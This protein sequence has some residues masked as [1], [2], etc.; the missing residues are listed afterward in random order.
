M[1]DKAEELINEYRDLIPNILIFGADDIRTMLENNR[2][3]AQT[4]N[5]F[6]LPGDVLSQMQ[7]RMHS[8]KME[9][10]RDS[11]RL[12]VIDPCNTYV[13]GRQRRDDLEEL[14]RM[15]SETGQAIWLYGEGGIGKTQIMLRFAQKHQEYKYVF[16]KY[17]SSIEQTVSQNLFFL[18]GLENRG[19]ELEDIV[20]FE[21]NMEVFGSYGQDM[22]L[23]IDGYD[24]DN[25]EE[26]FREATE[27][28]L[29]ADNIHIV[30]SDQSCI[31]RLLSQKI[32][33]IISTRTNPGSSDSY[34]I[35][36]IQRMDEDELL[37]VMLNGFPAIQLSLDEEKELMLREMIKEA[38]HNTVIIAIMAAAMQACGR[39]PETAL[40]VLHHS[41]QS[42]RIESFP[43]KKYYIG[44]T[45]NFA[46]MAQHM[47][48][49][50]RFLGLNWLQKE[51]LRVVAMLPP[52][53]VDYELYK[54]ITESGAVHY[55]DLREDM[56]KRFGKY[57]LLTMVKDDDGQIKRIRVH[58]MT[59]RYALWVLQQT[60]P[61]PLSE[62]LS[63][64]WTR[65][66]LNYFN[67]EKLARLTPS[68][69]AY[70]NIEKVARLC[71]VTESRLER[72]ES[73]FQTRYQ[74]L[75]KAAE[76]YLK[77]GNVK[78]ALECTERAIAVDGASSNDMKFFRTSLVRFGSILYHV[79]RFKDSLEKDQQAMKLMEDEYGLD[80]EIDVEEVIELIADDIEC[81]Q[82]TI[83]CNNVGITYGELGEHHRELEYLEKALKIRK[84]VL[85]ENH[86]DLATSYDN[87]GMTYGELG[88]HRRA[89]E[90][91]EKALEIRKKV[92]PE[93]HPDILSTQR[94]IE[95]IK[96][97]KPVK[98]DSVSDDEQGGNRTASHD[99]VNNNIAATTYSYK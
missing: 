72:G 9:D 80:E 92:L 65:K 20:R 96:D 2:D 82:Y 68:D 40:K 69:E 87:V 63:L 15:F 66:L 55:D 99:T 46:D 90:Y 58:A 12:G 32:H 93:N 8:L 59:A 3:V 75:V 26:L 43:Q 98:N 41:I 44:Y 21:R 77:V 36:E 4:Y 31:N 14:E 5:E 76:L 16:V 57:N 47:E 49:I 17:T 19:R 18:K 53:G 81:N 38:E 11:I 33:V 42:P 61:K 94:I 39:D 23:L 1:R 28:Y 30:E 67:D 74:L 84:K 88:E 24:P 29:D 54:R 73:G 37:Q 27:G 25:Y 13:E 95:L 71:M 50:F 62:D 6:I 52:E 7:E 35:M 51:V 34:H 56:I 79:G 60:S 48:K 89:L 97:R 45:G 70:R 86:P 22:V 83:L 64:T 10:P 78:N 91:K 85:P